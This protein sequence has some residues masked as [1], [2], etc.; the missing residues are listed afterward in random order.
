LFFMEF[1]W[2]GWTLCGVKGDAGELRN[3]DRCV[4]GRIGMQV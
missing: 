2:S 4:R 1:F 3:W